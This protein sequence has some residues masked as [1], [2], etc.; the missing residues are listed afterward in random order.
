MRL[1]KIFGLFLLGSIFIAVGK[2]A[3]AQPAAITNL[4]VASSGF[5]HLVVSWTAPYDIAPTSYAIHISSYRVIVTTSDWSDNS[6][7][8]N[9]PYRIY[10]ATTT[11][12]G[13]TEFLTIT[14]LVNAQSY[15][16]AIR[17]STDG[18]DW[19]DLDTTSP[20][21][22]GSP[23]NS[24]PTTVVGHSPGDG[25]IVNTSTPTLSWSAASA[26]SNDA[27]YGDY[28]QSYTLWYS[29]MSNF[30][31][32]S[33]V[34][35][36]PSNSYITPTLNENTT[37][38][39]RVYA[40]DSAGLVSETVL[41]RRIIVNAVNSPPANFSLT[42][43]VTSEIINT[44]LPTFQWTGSLDIDPGDSVTYTL[45]YSTDVN[46]SA[47]A[48]TTIA[49]LTNNYSN[50]T[51]PLIENAR[52]Y[53]YVKA[54]DQNGAYT[55]SNTTET[56]WVNVVNNPP[57][58]FCQISPASST[59]ILI[60][61]PTFYWQVAIDPDPQDSVSYTIIY[62]SSDP[63]LS[64][65]Y[66][67][68]SGLTTNYY[69]SPI[70]LVEDAT[71]WWKVQATDTKPQTIETAI[72]SFVV[73][74]INNPPNNFNLTA[75]SG[76]ITTDLPTLYWQAAT[77]PDNDPITYNLYYST[78]S[79]F[80]VFTSSLNLTTN[81]LTI[82]SP[83]TE[84]ATYYWKV[85]AFDNYLNSTT[86]NQTFIMRINTTPENPWPFNLL[87][88][89][90]GQA[91]ST[92]YP[93][94]SWQATT[95]PDPDDFVQNYVLYYSS[96]INFVPLNSIIVATTYY[97]F[98]LPL[99]NHSTYYWSVQAVSAISGNRFSSTTNYFLITNLAPNNFNLLSSS[100]IIN[101][102]NPTL[103]WQAAVD[104]DDDPVTY[105]IY[106][107]T[108]ASFAVASSSSGLTSTNYTPPS[109]LENT[110]YYWKVLA[111]DPLN[112]STWSNI[113][114]LIT[115]ALSE[116]P[117]DFNLI[118]PKNI[119]IF[120]RRPQ[121]NWSATS[122]PDPGDSVVSYTLY[123]WKE[124]TAPTV[125]ADGL[126]QVGYTLSSDLDLFSTYYWNVSATDTLGLKKFS[127]TSYFYIAGVL[128]P[129]PV[130]CTLTVFASS[131]TLTWPA[132][133]TYSDGS[134]ATIAG[135]AIYRAASLSDL[136][137][138]NLTTFVAPTQLSWTDTSTAARSLYYLVRAR[139]NF[140]SE[141]PAGNIA[142]KD[143]YDIAYQIINS[144]DANMYLKVRQEIISA[145]QTIVIST[146]PSREADI[147]KNL[148]IEY[149]SDGQKTRKTWEA[150]IA[151][152]LNI[153]LT[154][155][156]NP[157]P[158]KATTSGPIIYQIN[159][160]NGVKWTPIYRQRASLNEWLTLPV[161]NSGEYQL[162]IISSVETGLVSVWPKIITPKNGDNINDEFNVIIA[163]PELLSSDGI[164]YD[165]S[166]GEIA[167]M[168]NKTD[169]W[170]YWDGR[171]KNNQVCRPGI[172][173][174]QIKIGT[175]FY[176]G[177]LVVAQ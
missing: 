106:Y 32:K 28:I 52:Y 50:P 151:P 63:T 8:P 105:T 159:W 155:P 42:Y 138:T 134:S 18:L 65:N 140:G 149:Y 148:E 72:W 56:F 21:P 49:N 47:T 152:E 108:D 70:N 31:I 139:D 23:V 131:L 94:L 133:S 89:T 16:L 62:S 1:K 99:N 27:N 130:N 66:N 117:D 41:T 145:N 103:G 137:T 80:S 164:I 123:L 118:S 158:P 74:A 161:I 146:Q 87:S 12:V 81:Q 142:F 78:S 86:V 46:F 101:N 68:A 79:D 110:T 102:L 35:N 24:A 113:F 77:D 176:N 114:K 9:Y 93:T 119:N 157:A 129:A 156:S 88:P 92:L 39:W 136:Y 44:D 73:N 167:R 3:W 116:P 29:T 143:Y 141:S 172:Y 96:N 13:Q 165:L 107:T 128:Q 15:F 38:Y 121:L 83:L 25:S 82:T 166:G 162:Q 11:S 10:W 60:A 22:W 71:Y 6:S 5:K 95:D 169:N 150:A 33:V 132:V 153:Q 171:D 48:S 170:F 97:N 69:L 58:D 126:T 51:G 84:N 154:G 43:P 55:L 98:S 111:S 30:N 34:E 67:Y 17:S 20:E 90:N 19:S 174:Y 75:P 7:S 135:Y 59:I 127:T 104:P 57:Q 45:I 53:W 54:I 36:I 64:V 112:N 147:L 120:S 61:Q 40:V 2:I 37:Y 26:G 125:Y 122:D 177:T 91:L 173:L 144:P 76:T 4:T 109:L 175:K 124:G 163:N 85:I 115:N 168:K 14:G 160:F 100:G